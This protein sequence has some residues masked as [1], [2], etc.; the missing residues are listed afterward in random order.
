MIAADGASQVVSEK[1]DNP[2]PGTEAAVTTSS[3]LG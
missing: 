2:F 1:I 3:E